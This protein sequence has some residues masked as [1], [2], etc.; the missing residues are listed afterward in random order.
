[1]AYST[2]AAATIDLLFSALETFAAAN[3]WTV[4][5][6]YTVKSKPS[7]HKNNC[8][9]QFRYDGTSPQA[10]GRSMG[11][12]QSLGYSGAG[13]YPGGHTDDSGS[14]AN[15]QTPPIADSTI[16]NSRCVYAMGDG[17]F[18]Y[19]FFEHDN[20][21]EYYI[22]V[23]VEILT[24]EYR[25]FGFGLIDKFGDWGA[26]ASGGE[27]CYGC[28]NESG[29]TG[30]DSNYF[31]E[32]GNGTVNTENVLSAATMHAEGLPGEPDAATKWLAF[33]SYQATTLYTAN[34]DRAG[35]YRARGV[36]NSR[37]GPDWT[38]K[39]WFKGYAGFT[40][41]I[42]LTA[43]NVY[44]LDLTNN[45]SYLLGTALDIRMC[46]I[47]QFDPG[48]EVV[49]GSDTWVFFPFTKKGS[50]GGVG[51]HFDSYYHGVAYRKETT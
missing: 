38:M 28:R 18:N 35:V 25:H 5:E 10:A 34:K 27:Y 42:P 29:I 31:L 39:G 44:Y 43:L 46:N 21:T 19:W 4:D 49:I 13:T 37:G 32:G 17:P 6:S 24:G 2:G 26:G 1:M 33:F 20:G 48:E 40:G 47:A 11:V 22:H 14:G 15:D 45:R 9:V 36:S 3:G 8:Y 16:D 12:Y 51:P 7:L 30:G 23:V 41:L 50:I